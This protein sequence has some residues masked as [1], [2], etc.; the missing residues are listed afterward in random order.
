MVDDVALSTIWG[1]SKRLRRDHKRMMFSYSMSLF[2]TITCYGLFLLLTRVRNV[3][4]KDM[5]L[6]V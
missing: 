6:F 3:H 1:L 5:C 4:G 2:Q